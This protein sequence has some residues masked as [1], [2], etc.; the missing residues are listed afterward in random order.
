MFV[1]VLR[2]PFIALHY[3]WD[4]V[5]LLSQI[6]VVAY[7]DVTNILA[8]KVNQ[9][10]QEERGRRERSFGLATSCQYLLVMP[11]AASLL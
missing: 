5:L 1:L 6:Y 7:Q 3:T 2:L 8:K 11:H 4:S 10:N 9:D